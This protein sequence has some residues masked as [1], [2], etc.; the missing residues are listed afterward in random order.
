MKR[1]SL[2]LYVVLVVIMIFTPAMVYSGVTA[3]INLPET[4]QTQSY[5][6][7]DDGDYQMGVAWPGPRFVDN[8]DGTITDMLTGLMWLQ[9][10]N[11][12]KTNYSTFDTDGTA[13]D[14]G[15][16]WGKALLFIKEM[17]DG[18]VRPLC[19]TGKTGWR[20]PN[21]N[22]LESLVN[23]GYMEEDCIGSGGSNPCATLAEWLVDNG[24]Q[25]VETQGSGGVWTDQWEYGAYWVS[26]PYTHVNDG[27]LQL[28]G[29]AVQMSAGDYMQ[30]IHRNPDYTRADHFLFVWPVRD[31]G[32]AGAVSLPRTGA[33]D[34]AGEPND[35]GTIAQYR[36]CTNEAGTFQ[37]CS[38]LPNNELRLQDGYQK[39]GVTWPTT[40]NTSSGRYTNNS[41]G[42]ITD[43]LTGLMW[44][45]D[46]SCIPTN[47]IGYDT[48]IDYKCTSPGWKFCTVDSDCN[49]PGTCQSWNN[50]C[51]SDLSITCTTDADCPPGTCTLLQPADGRVEWQPALDF[52]DGINN[53]GGT[54]G[55]DYFPLC[56]AGYSDWR[57]PNRVEQRTMIKW[58]GWPAGY[59][60]PCSGMNYIDIWLDDGVDICQGI[61]G[62]GFLNVG[63]G[64]W[65]STSYSANEA[66]VFSIGEAGGIW[67]TDKTNSRSVWPVRTAG[68]DDGDGVP[69]EVE[70]NAPN[71][72]D[73]NDDG[74]PDLLQPL[75]TSL[76]SATGQGYV[77]VVTSGG[78]CTQNMNVQTAV[79]SPADPGFSYPLGVAGF[80]IRCSTGPADMEIIYHGSSDLTGFVYRNYGSMAPAF[81]AP[82]W[83]EMTGVTFG[84][85]V[86]D[87]QTVA[88]ATF[89]IG[90]NQLGDHDPLGNLILSLGGPGLPAPP[91]AI[92]TMTQWGMV[93]FMLLAVAGAV[94]YLRRRRYSN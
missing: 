27:G 55:T 23:S 69:V 40:G 32:V 77:T 42:T 72:G 10:A 53:V 15:V 84:T 44:L 45:E 20:M 47:Y 60:N 66:W 2:F 35:T 6:A 46:A 43:L 18:G 61:D 75:V 87:G 22:E 8:S 73:G 74:T 52:V 54:P 9:D 68:G 91:M 78:G 34:E 83:Y 65:T 25:Y 48:E 17:N 3:V 37:T 92:P 76:P 50:L 14:G 67:P 85:R 16:G 26:T 12:I 28:G 41:D 7:G 33:D 63:G 13:Q 64:Y 39:A 19:D 29:W 1:T 81:G 38:S 94:Y 11:C 80:E 79:A 86:I 49:N 51:E 62:Q 57:L 24:F 89:Q 4:G 59:N 21:V 71:N 31:A 88:T 70:D 30:I 58:Y 5:S 90:D 93:A 82:E 36:Y 56:G